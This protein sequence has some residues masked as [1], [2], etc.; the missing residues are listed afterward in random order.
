[1][2]VAGSLAV[3]ALRR[4]V[5]VSFSC[6]GRVPLRIDVRASGPT[7]GLTDLLCSV[8][9]DGP[10]PLAELLPAGPGAPLC[11]VTCDDSAVL[12]DRVRTIGERRRAVSLAVV[13]AGDDP[14]VH[15]AAL[16]RIGVAGAA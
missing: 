13:R 7:A 10:R 11:I 8:E 12:A 4:G 6:T 15:L 14:A 3:Q 2:R 1:M 9:A 16:T 5:G